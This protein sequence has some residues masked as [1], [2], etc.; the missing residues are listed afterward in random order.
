M[1][2]NNNVPVI[3]ILTLLIV[4]QISCVKISPAVSP[5]ASN[6]DNTPATIEEPADNKDI[7][8]NEPTT[9]EIIPARDT[10]RLRELIDTGEVVTVEGY[11]VST[12]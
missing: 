8:V 6:D 4:L 1:F 7:P 3:L 2:S 9:K 11:I 5:P 12:F 10:D